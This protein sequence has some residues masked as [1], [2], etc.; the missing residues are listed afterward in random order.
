MTTPRA[1]K[2][3][4]KAKHPAQALV[5]EARPAAEKN[6]AA[7]SD[8]SLHPS[9]TLSAALFFTAFYL[10]MWKWV[11]VTLIYHGGGQMNDF[12]SFYWG[13]EF[14]REFRTHP[15][16]FVEYISSLLAQS[17]YFSW[18][19]GLVL[20]LQAALVY[21]SSVAFIRGFGAEALRRFAFV[22]PLVLLAVYAKYRHYSSQVTSLAIGGLLFWAWIHAGGLRPRWRVST[23]IILVGLLFIIAPSAL[24]IFLPAV[25][26]FEL[27]S[28][29]S[30][31]TLLALLGISSLAPWVEG[32]LLFGFAAGESYA[33]LLPFA[34]N[35]D[36]WRV[37]GAYWI[38]AL[39]LLPPLA[40]FAGILWT[41]C[42][43]SSS[44]K[45]NAPAPPKNSA[46]QVLRKWEPVGWG[47]LPLV[48][49]Y[50]FLNVHL[51]VLL[52]VDYLAW[53][54][55]WSEIPAAAKRNARNP[56]VTCA[57]AQASYHTGGLT[58]KVPPVTAPEE[59]LFSGDKLQSHWKK[60]DLYFDLGYVN[61]ALHHLTEAVEFYG[62]RP[63]LLQRLVLINLALG[64]TSTAEVYLGTLARAPFQAGWAQAYLQRLKS[65]PALASDEE[66]VRLRRLMVKKDSVVALSADEEL[67]MLLDANR[68][69]RMAFEYLMTY[70]LLTKNLE[71]FVK[72]ISRAKDFPDLGISPLWDEGIVL[73]GRL[74]GRPIQL[75][76]HTIS[77]EAISRVNTVTR[78]AQ[79]YGDNAEQARRELS[80]NYAH[81]YTFYWLFH[82]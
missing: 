58:L 41:V 1:M 5:A 47:L 50:A 82:L 7:V 32:A 11:D 57:L 17:L 42:S 25:M 21:A 27:R 77:P 24:I 33:K 12:P 38:V 65:D 4:K 2:A 18:F 44:A 73:A 31:I 66:I 22:P 8:R 39:F 36:L 78:L 34:L 29:A 67:I 74:S 23:A 53:H 63:L 71:A 56:L 54:G 20:T 62:E 51:K 35:P 72:N 69:N 43:Q 61:M 10:C 15:G 26:L 79:R 55:R 46:I 45:Q 3:T 52:K 68:H 64:N 75:G 49:C 48:L 6:L 70:Y 40:A 81:T 30:W 19:G 37:T 60:S 76:G 14:A 9:H 59:L 28:G 16:G 80:A 13:G